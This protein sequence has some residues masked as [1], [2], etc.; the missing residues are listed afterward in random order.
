MVQYAR[1]VRIHHIFLV[2]LTAL[3]GGAALA[4]S[5][6]T[7]EPTRILLTMSADPARAAVVTWRTEA[8]P[9][10]AVG[11]I[12]VASAD[13]RFVKSAQSTPAVSQAVA[14]A[15]GK[16]ANYHTVRFGGLTPDTEYAYRV[17][18]G[19]E[20]SEWIHFRTAKAQPAPFSFIYFGDAQNDLKSLWSRTI[21][22]AFREEPFAHFMLHAGDLV[23]RGN[24]DTEWAEWFYAGGWIHGQIPTVATPGNHEYP[25]DPQDT[26]IRRL[27][28]LW[29]PQFAFP[30]N[31]LP[32]LERTNYWFDYQGARIVSLNSNERIAE[33][34]K[35]LDDILARNPQKW[36][37]VTFHHP[38]YS[39]AQGR[40]NPEIR[41]LWQ[42]IFQ[43]HNV[44]IVLQGHDHTYGRQN[45]PTGLA[46][47]DESSGTVYVVSVSGPKM[48]RLGEETAK[49]MSRRAE[50]SQLFQIVRVRPEK[51]RFE[52]YLVT[53]EL[54][55][56]FELTKNRDGSNRFVKV[57]V[58]GKERIDPTPS[59]DKDGQT[60]R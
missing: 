45:V 60:A 21:R 26:K 8:A 55:D 24:S 51:V 13:P 10:Q 32:G 3:L 54:Y 1:R 16:Q 57:A 36:T 2:L 56:A 33:Q 11:Q 52:A 28:D 22:R 37:F 19:K 39:T 48:Y 43:K 29:K 53:G 7:A 14:L 9:L 30:E 18:D 50:Y 17:G 6:A 40:D 20:W 15:E 42:P 46:G 47:R 35:W 41:R 25:R 58:T 27:S 49:T 34:A 59:D 4:Q 38:V 23:D 12:A 44:A 5:A 31:G